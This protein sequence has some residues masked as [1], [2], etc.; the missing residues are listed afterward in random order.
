MSGGSPWILNV[1]WVRNLVGRIL[2]EV[3]VRLVGFVPLFEIDIEQLDADDPVPDS[4][5]V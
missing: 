4:L 1:G 5:A 2:I 3:V